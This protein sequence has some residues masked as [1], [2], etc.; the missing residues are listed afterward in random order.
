ML[1][2]RYCL[3]L[4]TCTAIY[5][6]LATKVDADIGNAAPARKNRAYKLDASQLTTVAEETLRRYGLNPALLREEGR[7]TETRQPSSC[8]KYA[9]E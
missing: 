4:A 9:Y 5:M 6:E 3:D 1:L 7:V 8:C 2:G